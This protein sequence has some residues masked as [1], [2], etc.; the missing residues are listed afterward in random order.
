MQSL[1]QVLTAA[2]T[3][4]ALINGTFVPIVISACSAEK[5][6]LRK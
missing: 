2:G 1:K 5:D 4:I 3:G 6:T